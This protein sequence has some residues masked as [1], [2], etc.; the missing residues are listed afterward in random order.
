[1]YVL[2]EGITIMGRNIRHTYITVYGLKIKVTFCP[3]VHW[4]GQQLAGLFIPGKKVIFVAT[5]GRTKAEITQT[6]LHELFHAAV[7]RLGLNNAQFSHDIEEIIVDNFANV[8]TEVFDF[9][10]DSL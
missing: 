7:Y 5:E 8:L 2:L 6:F 10:I 1:M 4:E 9:D 3:Y